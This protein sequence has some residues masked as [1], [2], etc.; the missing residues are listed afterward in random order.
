MS[1]LMDPGRT[2][3]SDRI[4]TAEDRIWNN[5]R[6][7]KADSRTEPNHHFRIRYL[8]TA[9]IYRKKLAVCVFC[10]AYASLNCGL[11]LHLSLR[12]HNS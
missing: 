3:G 1:V 9:K 4:S 5:I 10:A 12:G 2:V 11:S 8:C 7:T 6:R